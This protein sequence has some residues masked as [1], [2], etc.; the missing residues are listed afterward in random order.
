[1][2]AGIKRLDEADSDNEEFLKDA[3]KREARLTTNVKKSID[4]KK[5][6]KA[7]NQE[8]ENNDEKGNASKWLGVLRSEAKLRKEKEKREAADKDAKRK[9]FLES[10]SDLE[11][12][13]DLAGHDMFAYLD[14]VNLHLAAE[15]KIISAW[16]KQDETAGKTKAK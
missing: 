9:A 10:D 11:D 13:E 2:K 1:M 14:K 16:N 8:P 4:D 5:S 3:A 15:E 6:R 12:L 7:L